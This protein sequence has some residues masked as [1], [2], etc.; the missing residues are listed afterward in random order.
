MG[1]RSSVALTCCYHLRIAESPATGGGPDVTPG[2]G[3]QALAACVHCIPDG[4]RVRF[5]VE[6]MSIFI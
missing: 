2:H 5:G 4:F 6:G 1:D 3:G